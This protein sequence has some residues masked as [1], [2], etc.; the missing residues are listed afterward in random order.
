MILDTMSEAMNI[1]IHCYGD[2]EMLRGAVNSVPDWCDIHIFDG[3]YYSFP[4]D[5]D[6]TPGLKQWCNQRN[7]VNLHIP[8]TDRLP[9][10]HSSS[11]SPELR[12]GV[13]E[14]GQWAVHD[15]LPQDE[16]TLKL[17][18]DERILDIDRDSLMSLSEKRKYSPHVN[19]DRGEWGD[20]FNL[21]RL[22]IPKYWTVWADD[23]FVWREHYPRDT[24][25]DTLKYVTQHTDENDFRRDNTQSIKIE[26]IGA[27]RDREYIQSR[28]EHL[29]NF[30]GVNRAKR[31]E[32]AID[33]QKDE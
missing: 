8:D 1:Q 17:D 24:D 20:S 16:W 29:K 18:T 32:Q 13:T 22:Y 19:F 14:K 3:R 21:T 28:I 12:P 26:N 31:L 6:K 27:E 11:K 10:G 33:S 9:F 4:G 5:T 23:C 2:L 30:D 7:D 25:I 15:V